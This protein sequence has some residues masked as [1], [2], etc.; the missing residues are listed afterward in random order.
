MCTPDIGFN[1]HRVLQKRAGIIEPKNL[2]FVSIPI[3][4]FKS[5]ENDSP[6]PNDCGFNSHRVLQKEGGG[7]FVSEDERFNSH[8]VLQKGQCT[9]TLINGY[10]VSIP[11]GYFKRQGDQHDQ[12]G[13]RV[14]IPIGYFKRGR[15]GR[16]RNE[17]VEFQFP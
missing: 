1:S 9:A 8:R 3:G 14:S 5:V 16:L 11:I 15:M 12:R 17:T 13:F 4:Y 6:I 7:K 10:R 2:I